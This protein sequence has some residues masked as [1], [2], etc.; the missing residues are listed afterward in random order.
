MASL[1]L[2]SW[3]SLISTVAI[4]LALA[5]AGLQVR[6]ANRSRS[7]QAAAVLIQ[8]TQVDSWTRAMQNVATL[9]IGASA[10]QV[11]ECDWAANALMDFGVRLEAVG[12]MVFQRL[13]SL[14]MADKLLGGVTL[15]FWN[16]VQGWLLRER[17]RSGNPNMF[18]WCEWL[19]DRIRDRR[20]ATPHQPAQ[21]QHADWR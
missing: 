9:P 4:V 3:L 13:V 20:A 18:E 16:R 1:D 10:E 5:F 6:Q 17:V 19:A 21:I 11:D 2:Q 8:N 12:Y 15:M 14:E 7:D